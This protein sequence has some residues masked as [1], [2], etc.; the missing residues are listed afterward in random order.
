MLVVQTFPAQGCVHNYVPA[1]EDHMDRWQSHGVSSRKFVKRV[2]V[3]KAHIG[4]HQLRFRQSGD[5][6]RAYVSCGFD[7]VR[8]LDLKT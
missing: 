8:S 4:N 3:V 6:L 1:L 2:S 7:L 5:D